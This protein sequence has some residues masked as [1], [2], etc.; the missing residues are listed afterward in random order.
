MSS[1]LSTGSSSTSLVFSDNV[2][3]NI[4]VASL[5]VNKCSNAVIWTGVFCSSMSEFFILSV[6][7]FASNLSLDP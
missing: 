5:V 6:Y 4:L 2:N 3:F 1:G 7:A